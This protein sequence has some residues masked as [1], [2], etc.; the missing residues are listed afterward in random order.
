MRIV[1]ICLTTPHEEQE[2]VTAAKTVS[3][4]GAHMG[5]AFSLMYFLTG[6]AAFG[7]L[8]AVLEPIIN[9]VLLPL[10]ERFWHGMHKRFAHARLASLAAEKLSQTAMHM[11]VAFGVIYWATGSLAFGGLAA[12]LEPIIN[13]V[14]LPFHDG[15]WERLRARL[16]A[17]AQAPAALAIAD[18]AGGRAAVA[19]A[20]L[21]LAA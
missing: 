15:L 12:V 17:A 11:V 13:V 21:R 14:V 8:A 10:H 9:V 18:N 6:S 4:V 5:I 16:A 19:S 7:G 20:Q 2:M 1:I 3:Q